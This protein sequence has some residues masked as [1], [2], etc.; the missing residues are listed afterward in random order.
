VQGEMGGR[1]EVGRG[2]EARG[3][4]EPFEWQKGPCKGHMQ[5]K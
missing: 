5:S 3:E 2:H 1:R 4:D